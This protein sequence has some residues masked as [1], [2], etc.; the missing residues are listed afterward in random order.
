MYLSKFCYFAELT[1]WWWPQGLVNTVGAEPEDKEDPKAHTCRLPLIFSY[2]SLPCCGDMWFCLYL[3]TGWQQCSHLWVIFGMRAGHR[4]STQAL[5]HVFWPLVELIKNGHQT[6]ICFI[7]NIT[8]G[9]QLEV[10]VIHVMHAV[11]DNLLKVWGAM[12]N[13]TQDGPS[14][15]SLSRSLNSEPL[16]TRWWRGNINGRGFMWWMA[17]IPTYL[18]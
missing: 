5:P 3:T 6:H 17:V 11:P 1:G 13:N 18:Q 10:V 2:F 7:E 9:T 14:Q 8:I 16:W 15:I 12:S 4:R